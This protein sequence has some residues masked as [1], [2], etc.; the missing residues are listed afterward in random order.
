MAQKPAHRNSSGTESCCGKG[1]NLAHG[2]GEQH[3]AGIQMQGMAGL[4]LSLEDTAKRSNFPCGN[5]LCIISWRTISSYFG[6]K[7]MQYS[8]KD[9]VWTN[10]MSAAVSDKTSLPINGSKIRAADSVR[11]EE[12]GQKLFNIF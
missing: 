1:S 4:C 12:H 3:N 11:D 5:M 7:S 2:L 6:E 9:S 10:S 8:Q